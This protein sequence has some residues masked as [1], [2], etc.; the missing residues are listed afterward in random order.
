MYAVHHGI[1]S[2]QT[3]GS[4]F[5]RRSSLTTTNVPLYPQAPMVPVTGIKRERSR[6]ARASSLR[7][8]PQL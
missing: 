3:T 7:L 8:P 4:A 5:L 1:V 6:G 2:A